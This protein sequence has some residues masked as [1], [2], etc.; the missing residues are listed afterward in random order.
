MEYRH[1][2]GIMDI[3][4]Y[5]LMDCILQFQAQL[6][7]ALRFEIRILVSSQKEFISSI[8]IHICPC[9]VTSRDIHRIWYAEVA[10]NLRTRPNFGCN[11]TAAV[12]RRA[13]GAHLEHKLL[14][15]CV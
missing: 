4:C 15:T 6:L 3:W 13:F 8:Y 7:L 5:A 14:N 12:D 10:L 11:R 9:R 1:G 2:H